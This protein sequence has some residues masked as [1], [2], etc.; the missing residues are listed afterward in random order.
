MNQQYQNLTPAPMSA[1]PIS[2]GVI[3][4]C[5]IAF[6]TRVQP[7]GLAVWPLGSGFFT[8]WQLVSYAFLHGSF[9]HLFFTCQFMSTRI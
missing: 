8:P 7:P 6:F 2:F 5:A 9:N 3:I 1:T 4:I